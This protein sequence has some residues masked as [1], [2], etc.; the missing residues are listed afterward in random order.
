MSRSLVDRRA[1]LE[2]LE[3]IEPPAADATEEQ[4]ETRGLGSSLLVLAGIDH[5][6][7]YLRCRAAAEHLLKRVPEPP[8]WDLG[9][10]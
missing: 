6:Q 3:R 2:R 1:L 10:E 7:E 5:E 8:E 4:F 9:E